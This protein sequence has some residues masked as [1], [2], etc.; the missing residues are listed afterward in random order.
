MPTKN[1]AARPVASSSRTRPAP[2]NSVASPTSSS[3]RP[4]TR[5]DPT[6]QASSSKRKRTASEELL[7]END[8]ARKKVHEEAAYVAHA[9]VVKDSQLDEWKKVA[10]T[11]TKSLSEWRAT[12][13]DLVKICGEQAATRAQLKAT[14]EEL[15]EACEDLGADDE[16]AEGEGGPA[17]SKDG[18]STERD[19]LSLEQARDAEWQLPG[20]VASPD[21]WVGL[22]SGTVVT[23]ARRGNARAPGAAGTQQE[24]SGRSATEGDSNRVR[25]STSPTFASSS[26]SDTTPGL[27]SCAPRR[28]PARPLNPLVLL[29]RVAGARSFCGAMHAARASLSVPLATGSSELPCIPF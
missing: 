26:S 29:F 13:L 7:A 19:G 3:A 16:T 15:A 9:E 1:R 10:N 14:D 20:F 28:Q 6:L 8:T 11:N 2:S 27:A 24:D 17:T 12:Q 21:W 23:R 25:F 18:P 5:A 4:Q 22:R